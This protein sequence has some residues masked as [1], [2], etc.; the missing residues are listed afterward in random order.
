MCTALRAAI[1]PVRDP[2]STRTLTLTLGLSPSLAFTLTRCATPPQPQKIM[3][4]LSTT[5]RQDG[6]PSLMR[7]RIAWATRRVSCTFACI[8]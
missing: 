3:P 7:G 8:T 1:R 6:T 2:D 4:Q 5:W